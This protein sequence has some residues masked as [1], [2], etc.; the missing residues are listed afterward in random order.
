MIA[1]MDKYSLMVFHA[2]LPEFLEHL[3][4]L[5]VVD[6]TRQG[7]AIDSKSKELSDL[8][9]RYRNIIKRIDS[10]TS[11]VEG[12]GIDK[13]LVDL[14]SPVDQLLQQ[15][16]T[17]Y[18]NRSSFET[19]YQQLTRD[20][21]DAAQWGDYDS[22]DI[23]RLKAL[24]FD[25]HFYTTL[26]S[27]FNDQWQK[28]HILHILNKI[29]GKVY[30]VILSPKG[31]ELKFKLPESKFPPVPYHNIELKENNLKA[32]IEINEKSIASFTLCKN[33]FRQRYESLNMELD[34]YLAKVSSKKEVEDFI[35]TLQGFAPAETRENVCTFL[36]NEG[37]YYE[38]EPA[39]EE[40]NPPIKLK[41][42]FF[43][44]LFEPIGALYMFP[45]YGE[46]DLTPYFAPFYM[47]FFGLCLGD[48]GY[49]LTLMI[50]GGVAKL[51]LP[52]MKSLLTL[53]QL[54]GL[55]AFLM[56][57]LTGTAF[58]GKLAELLPLPQSI[59]SL[60]FSDIK[61][62]WFAII[63]GLVHIIFARLITAID[64][65]IRKGWQYGMGN[66]GWVIIIIWASLA[67]AKTMMP[68]MTLPSWFNYLAI[69]GGILIL[70]FS[71][72]EGNIFL[73]ILKGTISLYDIT[74]IF[75]DM[76]SYIRLF[77]LGTSGG[78]LGMVI[79]SVAFSLTAIPYVGWFFTILLLIV[80]HIA[81]LGLSC[82]GAFVHPMRL[83]FV[84][85]YKNAGF[86]GGGK[87]FRPLR[88]IYEQ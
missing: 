52:K 39:K 76:L 87:E 46:L 30:F 20:K 55:G 50:V 36:D 19:E 79:N 4:E 48:M 85:F 12:N 16:E 29:N 73:R 74:G 67:Y 58:G 81:V 18:T 51:K 78:I 66:I 33:L 3:Q 38:L 83:T 32:Q 8:I 72:T 44:R 49:G 21:A 26:E 63:F 1:K 37:V 64:S 31:S 77:G 42:N 11:T 7:H 24:D 68:D 69:A 6:I 61:M 80:G 14:D 40:D 13:K 15:C 54:L 56:A 35:D 57:S 22:E 9:L 17:L 86:T 75:G 62:F 59:T 45:K 65:M 27:K 43:A 25:L 28:D 60:F 82:L 88:K 10:A 23:N 47:L 34:R 2:D 71:S 41:N 70:G 84:E 53:V 5:G